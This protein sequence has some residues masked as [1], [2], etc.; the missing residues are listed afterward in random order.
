MKDIRI[1]TVTAGNIHEHPQAVCFINPKQS[2]H[3]IKTE[4]LK[5]R[6]KE[7]LKIKLLYLKD[8]KKAA[9]FIEYVPGESAWRAVN[10]KGYM[11]IHCLWTYP[12]SIRGQGY[13]TA[14]IQDC[15]DDTRKLKMNGVAVM[16]SKGSFMAKS[17]IFIKNGF[18]IVEE[19][20]P[21]ALLLHPFRKA[22]LPT[23]TDTERS[24]RKYRD[25]TV[26]YSNQCPWVVRFVED[27]KDNAAILGF[28]VALKEIK[29]AK[30]AQQAPSA[31]S[32]FS[33]VYQG[34][35]LA[36][37]YISKTR[38]MNILKKERARKFR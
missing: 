12:N 6:F 17:D 25:M 21:H 27:L 5:K 22:P 32:A 11:F 18:R 2:C 13:G 34:R 36:D 29:T 37:H 35:L 15:A 23:F 19:K 38:L 26:I 24:L 14:L 30:Q 33:L 3:K 1:V 4:W 28:T 10:A 8:Q 7:G 9:G 31:Y 20:D 16:T